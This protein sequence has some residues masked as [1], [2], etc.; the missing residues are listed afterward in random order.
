MALIAGID[1]A[2]LG[3]VLGPM[4]V[5]TTAF[6]VP[7]DAL[8]VSLW[9]QLSGTI[10]RKI[11]KRRSL[12]AVAD[13]K[14]LYQGLR[15][16]DGLEHLERG[17]LCMLGTTGLRPR[18]LR[19]LLAAV[20][21]AAG[22]HADGYPWYADADVSIPRVHTAESLALSINSITRRMDDAGVRMVGARSEPVFAAEY[23]RLVTATRNKSVTLFGVTA[24]LLAHL[25]ELTGADRR[26]RV[27]V[28]RQGGRM[29]YRPHLQ[30]IFPDCRLKVDDETV[31]ASAYRVVGTDREMEIAF[32]VGCEDRQLPVAL[33]SMLSKYVR[34]MHMALLN[35]F[36][37]DRVPE[38]APTGGYYSDGKRFYAEIEPVVRQL[39]LDEA[40]L[41][42]PR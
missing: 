22:D 16:K 11:H 8:D 14:K 20:A 31:D 28:D 21:P 38:I 33:A 25:W 37:A 19:E 2:G 15:G 29:R 41:Y 12:V 30:R 42:R 7:D 26:M 3:P 6:E 39:G 32:V 23:N 35:R 24:R 34:E 27:F 10:C 40:M 9:R 1:E 18:T 13:S 5:S 4:V 17:V 36:W